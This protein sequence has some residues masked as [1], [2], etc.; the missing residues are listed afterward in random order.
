VL[1]SFLV[2]A[3]VLAAACSL[4]T[5]PDVDDE[6]AESSEAAATQEITLPI[7]AAKLTQALQSRRIKKK[8]TALAALPKQLKNHFVLVT[9]T[10][11]LG[12]ASRARPRP[13]HF[14]EDARFIL[15][16][17]GHTAAQGDAT[18]NAFEIIE[19]NEATKTFRAHTLELDARTGAKLI[20]DDTRCVA[21][22]GTPI[23]P[24]WGDYPNWPNSYGGSRGHDGV[25]QMTPEEHTAFDAFVTVAKTD[26][27]YKHLEIHESSYGFTLPTPYGYP[28]TTFT[29][30]LGVR[31]GEQLGAKLLVSPNLAKLE[32]A[33]LFES[34]RCYPTSSQV[35]TFIDT[36]YT[37]LVAS[38][39]AV[40]AKHARF[41]ATRTD[42]K[43]YRLLGIEPTTDLRVERTVAGIPM[44]TAPN[45]WEV[46]M[47]DWNASADSLPALAE[48]A[49]WRKVFAT[50]TTLAAF[51]QTTRPRF[52]LLATLS[53][54]GDATTLGSLTSSSALKYSESLFPS[55]HFSVH[56]PVMNDA[57]DSYPGEGKRAAICAHL[58]S[59]QKSRQQ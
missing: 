46:G 48:F 59:S 36:R 28:N 33:L 7:N 53:Y 2:S 41:P 20:E 38:D 50:D 51:Y 24:I 32:Y 57:T 30:R 14:T 26:A 15:A 3:L 31:Y 40:A 42:T 35:R 16:S 44:G 52:D 43:M 18:A 13:V 25:D 54:D 21:C 58:E 34:A 9:E 19:W 49:V 1:R 22:H 39:P 56:Y 11:G 8:S 29:G 23:R 4:N 45:D 27:D 12:M 10:G 55:L 47:N 5:G 6:N 37:A 17:S